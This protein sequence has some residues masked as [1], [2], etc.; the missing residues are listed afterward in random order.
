MDPLADVEA[1]L[2]K[3]RVA[4][5]VLLT[6]PA[7]EVVLVEPTYKDGWEVPGGL[8]EQGE[9]PRAA[10]RREVAEELGVDLDVGPLLVVHWDDRGRMPGDVVAFVFDG[11]TTTATT[12]DVPPDELRSARFVAPSALGDHLR[13]GPARRMLAAIEA[14][15]AGHPVYLE[16]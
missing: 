14:R 3:K 16:R 11:G 4:A 10:A 12:F 9:S 6:N 2:P 8:V 1:L 5:G 13:P 7:G 15:E